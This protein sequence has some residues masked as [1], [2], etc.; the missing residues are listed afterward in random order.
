MSYFKLYQ[1]KSG[2]SLKALTLIARCRLKRH[3]TH[4]KSHHQPQWGGSGKTFCARKLGTGSETGSV[5][6]LG[7]HAV[8]RGVGWPTLVYDAHRGSAEL[9]ANVSFGTKGKGFWAR[10]R[11]SQGGH[12]FDQ[13]NGTCQAHIHLAP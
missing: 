7:G 6:R 1:R 12:T 5:R 9:C 4:K 11:L 3:S 13:H 8:L 10:L 2:T